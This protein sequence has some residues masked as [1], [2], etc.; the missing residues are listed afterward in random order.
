M[1]GMR[2]VV[3]RLHRVL[4]L[5]LA[6][7]AVAMFVAFALHT[8]VDDGHSWC[9]LCASAAGVAGVIKVSKSGFFRKGESVVC[10]LTG[11]GL[12]DADFSMSIAQKPITIKARLDDVL[13][14]LG[15]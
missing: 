15:F 14:V 10:T 13:K 7:I 1:T 4:R 2:V 11:H 12:K 3:P 5:T 6:F 9:W 8:H